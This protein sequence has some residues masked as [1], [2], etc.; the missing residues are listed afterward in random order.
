[1][2]DLIKG[3]EDVLSNVKADKI[4]DI[5]DLIDRR[6]KVQDNKITMC[7]DSLNVAM[8]SVASIYKAIEMQTTHIDNVEEK[9]H[10]LGTIVSNVIDG[11]SEM[12]A[13][14]TQDIRSLKIKLNN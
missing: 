9:L 2:K 8:D 13:R 1:M 5:V 6:F 11:C 12:D 10:S 3:M 7:L 4:K 14:H